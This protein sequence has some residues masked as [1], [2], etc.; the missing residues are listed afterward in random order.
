MF[1]LMM[2]EVRVGGGLADPRSMPR[3]S[4]TKRRTV[5]TAEMGQLMDTPIVTIW[6]GPSWGAVVDRALP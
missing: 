1:F 4:S 3:L 2:V 6:V 5:R